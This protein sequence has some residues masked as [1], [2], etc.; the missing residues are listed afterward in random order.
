MKVKKN[1]QPPK[2]FEMGT[3]IPGAADHYTTESKK[4]R[5]RT[6]VQEVLADDA[7]R[8]RIR[9][10]FAQVIASKRHFSNRHL[11]RI[12]IQERKRKRQARKIKTT[13]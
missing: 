11:N 4:K 3:V 2:Y 5:G 1:F 8:E 7:T 13:D 6:L 10:R 12:A 9:T